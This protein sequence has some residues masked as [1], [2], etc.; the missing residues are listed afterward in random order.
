MVALDNAATTNGNGADHYDAA[1]MKTWFRLLAEK[2][3]LI[4]QEQELLVQ[5]KLLELEDGSAKLERE[6]RGLLS[7][8]GGG[9]AKTIPREGELLKE[10]VEMSEQK[11]LLKAMLAKDKAR[12]QKEDADI[13]AQMQAKIL[14]V[15][16]N[17]IVMQLM[18]LI[19]DTNFLCQTCSK[20]LKTETG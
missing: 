12:Y 10:L 19:H 8:E 9:S 17:A 16:S 14:K 1:L 5:A 15:F 18:N 20:H 3:S 13:E 4:R 2:N 6:L 7:S 11:D